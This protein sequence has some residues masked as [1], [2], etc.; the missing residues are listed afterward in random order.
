MARMGRQRKDGLLF[1]AEYRKLEKI[2]GDQ[3]ITGDQGPMW[4]VATLKKEKK[5]EL[6][7]WPNQ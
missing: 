5:K 7:L 3:G 2:S 6:P 1:P 4:R